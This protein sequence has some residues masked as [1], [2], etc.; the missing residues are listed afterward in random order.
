LRHCV[1][2]MQKKEYILG[3]EEE[4]SGKGALR[5][6]ATEST[7]GLFL[8]PAGAL[9]PQRRRRCYRSCSGSLVLTTARTT[10]APFLHRGVDV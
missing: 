9:S 7:L 10:A 6:G 2:Q 8:L 3:E 5:P 1:L 4:A